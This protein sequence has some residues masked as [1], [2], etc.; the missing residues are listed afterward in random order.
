MNICPYCEQ[1]KKS[2]KSLLAHKVKCPQNPE[3]NYVSYTRGKT[4]WNKGLTKET[5]SRVMKNAE[6]VKQAI[7]VL[8][9]QGIKTGFARDDFWTTERRQ[10]KSEW[11]KQLHRD[12]PE[13]HPNRKLAGNRKRMTYPERVAFDFLERSGVEFEHQMKIDAFFVDFIVGKTIIEIDGEYWHDP[14]AD[15]K[16]DEVLVSKGYVVHR[17]KAKERIEARISEILSIGV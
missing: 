11:R 2:K 12:H 1:E 15:A 14:D 13:M 16:R 8:S 6:S 17:I 3:R 9:E 7:Q 5:D 4:A 10:A